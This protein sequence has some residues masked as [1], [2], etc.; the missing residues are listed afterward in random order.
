MIEP[1]GKQP[2]LLAVFGFGQLGGEI[3]EQPLDVARA[4]QGRHLAHENGGLA[5]RLDHEAEPLEL[6]SGGAEIGGGLRVELDHFG[7]Q[8]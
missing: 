3:G 5:E 2:C 8:Q 4:E 6:G 7:D 1:R